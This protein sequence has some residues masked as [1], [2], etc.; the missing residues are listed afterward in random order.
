MDNGFETIDL[1]SLVECTLDSDIFYDLEG[2]GFAG[3]GVGGLDLVG[4]GL[5]ADRGDYCVTM[6]EE[7][8]EDVGCDEAA[9]TY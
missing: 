3:V 9:A 1:D 6:L 2:E 8:V 5:A 4:F 7:D